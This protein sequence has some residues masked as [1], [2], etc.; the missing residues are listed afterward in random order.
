MSSGL[1]K[2]C[3]GG[4]KLRYS[5]IIHL[6]DYGSRCLEDKPKNGG[7]GIALDLF[8]KYH[9]YVNFLPVPVICSRTYAGK[10]GTLQSS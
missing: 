8:E 1:P 2:E 6:T 5:S 3:H 9:F 7:G 10:K 4:S